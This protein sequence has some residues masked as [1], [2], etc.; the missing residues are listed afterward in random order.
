MAEI[1]GYSAIIAPQATNCSAPDTGNMGTYLLQL[2][3][4]VD[5]ELMKQRYWLD[6][7]LKPKRRNIS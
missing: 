6:S 7:E 5:R 1:M 4:M 3:H 2:Y